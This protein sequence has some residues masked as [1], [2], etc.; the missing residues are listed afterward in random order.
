MSKLRLLAASAVFMAPPM[1][2]SVQAAQPS[3][4]VIICKGPLDPVTI[5]ACAS[6][7]L[8]GNELLNGNPPF[9]PTGEGSKLLARQGALGVVNQAIIATG[10]DCPVPWRIFNRC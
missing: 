9:G 6:T 1:G 5:A 3:P 2:V 7:M 4:L 10:G 8:V